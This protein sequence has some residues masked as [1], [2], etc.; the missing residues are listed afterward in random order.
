MMFVVGVGTAYKHH[1]GIRERM[2]K[3]SYVTWIRLTRH[4]RRAV[5]RLAAHEHRPMAAMIRECVRREA[6][7]QGVWP[8][9]REEV[10]R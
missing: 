7:R 8:E 10:V 6:E 3:E 5:E 1:R 4:E 2:A 9:A